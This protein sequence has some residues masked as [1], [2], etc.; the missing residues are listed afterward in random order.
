VAGSGEIKALLAA[1]WHRQ[2]IELPEWWQWKGAT[3]EEMTARLAQLE[4]QPLA[5]RE[6]M[7][8][9]LDVRATAEL[10]DTWPLEAHALNQRAPV[11]LRVNSLRSSVA[12]TQAW[13]KSEGVETELVPGAPQALRLADG[14]MLPKPLLVDGRLEIQD[15][16][17]QLIIPM[18]DVQPGMKVIDTCAGAGGKT[19][20][21]LEALG[22]SD[23]LLAMDVFA[24]KLNELRRRAHVAGFNNVHTEVW[25]PG[26]LKNYQAAADRI[27][28]DAPCSGLGTLRRQP[29]LKWRLV[30]PALEKTRR[31]QRRLLDEYSQM[32][33]PGGV[34]VYATCS[35]LPTENR[36]QVDDFMH[37]DPR[38]E[39]IED[40]V[41]SPAA[42]GWDGFYAAKLLR[43]R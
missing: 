2:G 28:I 36:Q 38:W 25:K 14:K 40:R 18:L 5:L 33:R 24:P 9:W 42:T 43:K 6:S 4:D 37:R 12:E 3:A 7:P 8:D 41:I 21:I 34:M 27:L 30:E 10:G 32:V 16:G 26:T 13:L 23:G 35:I 1:H 29:D 31:L 39:L 17:S 22:S 20:Q 11:F 15:A 19:L